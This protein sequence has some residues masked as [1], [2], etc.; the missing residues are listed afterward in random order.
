MS[1]TIRFRGSRSEAELE[2]L[3]TNEQ[4]DLTT[5]AKMAYTLSPV[6]KHEMA[7]DSFKEQYYMW[8]CKRAADEEHE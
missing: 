2:R 4:M 7:F 6:F 1:G 3:F 8:R 5:S